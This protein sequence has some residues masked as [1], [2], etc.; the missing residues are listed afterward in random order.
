[1]EEGT[2]YK[3]LDPNI[4]N[5]SSPSQTVRLNEIFRCITIGLTCVQEYAE[6][7]P[8]MS[9]VVSMLGSD[10]DI[11]KPKPPGYCLAISSDP[12]TS[13]TIVCTTTELEP[14]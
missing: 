4:M 3:V 12:W 5:S 6:D 8:A 11:P 1:M 13:T 10:T 14:R 7:R 2:G 9:W